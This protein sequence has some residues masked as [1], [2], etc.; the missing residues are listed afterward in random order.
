MLRSSL[1][2]CCFTLSLIHRNS[3]SDRLRTFRT[4]TF[5]LINYLAFYVHH[6]LL[7]DHLTAHLVERAGLHPENERDRDHNP[8]Q[9]HDISVNQE[10]IDVV[11]MLGRV[12]DPV[13]QSDHL[14]AVC[15]Q[16]D[17]ELDAEESSLQL[18]LLEDENAQLADQL[19]DRGE[20]N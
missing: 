1:R 16:E 9:L 10:A 11:A 8:K 5:V 14:A 4:V 19:N 3:L 15:E 7:I 2:R 18:G 13:D 6:E 20:V 17:A 12:L